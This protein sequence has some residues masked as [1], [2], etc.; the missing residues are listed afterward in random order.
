MVYGAE[1]TLLDD[2]LEYVELEF[3]QLNPYNKLS[4]CKDNLY[5]ITKRCINLMEE[6]NL[7]DVLYHRGWKNYIAINKNSI[8]QIA[9]SPEINDDGTW[10]IDLQLHPGDTMNQARSFFTGINR[11]KLLELPNKG[12][13]VTPN[14]HFAYRSSNLVWPNVKVGTE[15]YIDHWLANI[16]TLGQINKVDFE[17]YCIELEKL[18]LIS[19]T[20]WSRINEKILSTNMPKIN[21]C[22]GVSLIYTWSKEDAIKLDENKKLSKDIKSK[23][24]EALATWE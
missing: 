17:Q 7:G 19:D 12:W 8:K 14:F 9:L 4:I 15:V 20:D 22:P 3:P 23:I 11:D 5:L 10:R 6:V 18:G 16:N 13:S 24:I 2:F 1:E 21:I